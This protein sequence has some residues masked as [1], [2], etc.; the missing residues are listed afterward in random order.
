MKKEMLPTALVGG[1]TVKTDCKIDF[2]GNVDELQ[3][4]IMNLYHYVDDEELKK[5]LIIIVKN[6]SKM[7][8]IVAGSSSTFSE[9]EL[10]E[11][12]KMIDKYLM[13]TG[14]LTCFSLPGLTKLSSKIHIVRTV[15]RRAERSYAKVYETYGGN[16]YIFEYLNK[17]STFFYNLALYYE[18][19]IDE[20]DRLC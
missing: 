19:D 4:Y 20:R 9:E 10:N 7:M 5:Y 2:F 16:N 14:K 1:M 3:A 8:G 6:L 12:L 17:L 18:K 15:C 13:L 11:L